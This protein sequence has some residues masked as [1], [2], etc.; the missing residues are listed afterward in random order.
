MRRKREDPS[1]VLIG[2]DT[3]W[4]GIDVPGEALNLLVITR[5]PFTQPGHPLT[6][7]RI[8]AIE[9]QGGSGF[10]HHS[11]PEAI[12]KFRQGFGRLVRTSRDR[13]KVVVLDPRARTRRYGREFL[14]GLPEGVCP[15][16]DW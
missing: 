15:S 4:E 9:A 14:A 16:E 1:T 2:T 11:L 8:R 13:G 5:F 7:A 12:L 6:E 10:L 3:M